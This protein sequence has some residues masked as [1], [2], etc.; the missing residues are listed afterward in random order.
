MNYRA[1]YFYI[2][3]LAA[4]LAV[5]IHP[6]RAA[7]MREPAQSSSI[8]SY[9]KNAEFIAYTN[10]GG[11]DHYAHIAQI[12]RRNDSGL[13]HFE[14]IELHYHEEKSQ[15]RIRADLGQANERNEIYLPGKVD[16]VSE[17]Y[18][19]ESTRRSYVETE[20]V[21]L[22]TKRRLA[23]TSAAVSIRQANQ[24]MRGVGMH[25]DLSS[26]EVKILNNIQ[27]LRE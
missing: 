18:G 13:T 7:S 16:I 12:E 2:F 19:K 20:N 10:Q 9:F 3:C 8:S 21:S 23:A 14:D 25:A 24:S 22:D 27:A 15:T 11:L 26:G 6:E 17:E 4:M 1:F 5:F